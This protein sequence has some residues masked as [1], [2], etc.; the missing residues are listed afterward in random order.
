MR[1]TMREKENGVVEVRLDNRLCP[2][3]WMEFDVLVADGQDAG[4]AERK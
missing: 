1:V 2:A 4:N 3:F